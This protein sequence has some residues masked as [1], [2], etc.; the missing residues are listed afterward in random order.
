LGEISEALKRAR[1]GGR[2]EAAAA[3]LPVVAR[4]PVTSHVAPARDADSA[5][6]LS[7]ALEGDWHARAVIAEPHSEHA[8]SYRHFA[9]RV[10]R[11][12]K[13]SGARSLVVTSAARGEGKTTTAS[14][15]ALALASMASGRRI[16]FVELDVR[17]PSAAEALG[18]VPAVGIERVLAGEARV[19]ETC[20]HTQFPELDLYL[21]AGPARDPLGL[22]SAPTTGVLLRDLSRQYDLLVI[23]TPPVLPVPDVPLLAAHADAALLVARH[24]VS[25]QA[26]LRE[27]A[28]LL[29]DVRLIGVFLN[30]GGTPRHRRYYGYYGYEGQEAPAAPEA[31]HGGSER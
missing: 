20:I 2:R 14:N 17:R 6:T 23:D 24:G 27:A 29:G 30:D 7:N 9:L 15:L 12:L 21:A 5:I 11:E 19:A 13:A 22:I 18:A 16:A 25:R 4:E 10:Q 26:A 8:E 28:E 1:E 3:A 31:P